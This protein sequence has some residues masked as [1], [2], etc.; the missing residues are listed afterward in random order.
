MF[1]L[2]GGPA[3]RYGKAKPSD[4]RMTNSRVQRCY[5]FVK[6]A[7]GNQAI[8]LNL[9]LPYPHASTSTYQMEGP[10]AWL[11]TLA[12]APG[13]LASGKQKGGKIG[14]ASL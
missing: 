5:H 4:V 8:A 13:E 12:F 3:H 1:E 6:R 9:D 7:A 10:T 2:R 11:P 14:P